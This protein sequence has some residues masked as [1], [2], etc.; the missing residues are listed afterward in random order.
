MLPC[1]A[2]SQRATE[3]LLRS[4]HGVDKPAQEGGCPGHPRSDGCGLPAPEVLA[5]GAQANV[6]LVRSNFILSREMQRPLICFH[7]GI[8]PFPEKSTW[9]S[10]SGLHP[11]VQ[12]PGPTIAKSVELFCGLKRI[13]SLYPYRTSFISYCWQLDLC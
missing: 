8:I 10:P 3:M 9:S 2:R 7:L 12:S 5:Y 6:G 1:L 4:A 11:G 13:S